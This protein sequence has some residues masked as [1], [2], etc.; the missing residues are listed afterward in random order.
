MN[1]VCLREKGRGVKPLYA[2]ITPE[3]MK[4]ESDYFLL[5]SV[6]CPGESDA[7]KVYRIL[8]NFSFSYATEL[9]AQTGEGQLKHDEY[10]WYNDHSVYIVCCYWNTIRLFDGDLDSWEY[11]WKSPEKHG[12]LRI[13]WLDE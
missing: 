3:D 4:P 12:L 9:F 2:S 13:D 7:L 8:N 11:K 10:Y 1:F 6:Y 5:E